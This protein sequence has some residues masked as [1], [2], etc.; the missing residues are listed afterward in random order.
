MRKRIALWLL[1][2]ASLSG[3]A[4]ADTP[5]E[6]LRLAFANADTATHQR[7]ALTYRIGN[8]TFRQQVT[9]VRP[10]RVHLLTTPENGPQQQAIVIG[11]TIFSKQESGAWIESPVPPRMESLNDPTAGLVK[12][13]SS[14]REGPH[15]THNGREQRV[16]AG[17]VRWQ[18][19]A[20]HNEGDVEVM[21]DL[22]QKLPTRITFTGRCGSRTC[23]FAQLLEFG[24]HL[25]VERP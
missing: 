19:G 9:K 3:G 6:A 22:L 24:P 16:F 14:L 12:L 13:L 15:Q 7:N 18:A 1:V 4:A 17:R 11:R 8:V 23:S 25:T 5:G 21:V 2:A 10:D 20:N